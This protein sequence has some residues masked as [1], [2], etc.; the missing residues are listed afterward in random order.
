[1]ANGKHL[2]D[3]WRQFAALL[4]AG[5]VVL[6]FG[7]APLYAQDSPGDTTEEADTSADDPAAAEEETAE[8]GAQTESLDLFELIFQR[9]GVL[10]IP[11]FIMSVIVV[12]FAIERGLALRRAKV[13]PQEMVDELGRLASAP[14]GFDPRKAYRIC[15]RYPSAV[16]NVIRAM[17][18]KV[19]RPHNEIEHAVKEASEREAGRL[20]SNV[21]Y[22]GL[23]AA[24]S[25]LLGLLG[26][27]WGM[28]IAFFQMT[29]LGFSANK[30]LKL[31][32]GIY[33]ALVTTLGGLAVA[34]P[35]AIIAHF[36]EGR[37]QALFHQIDE[38]LFSLLPQIERFE[39]R[40]RVNRQHLAAA[41]ETAVPPSAS[42]SVG[43]EAAS[44]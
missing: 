24:V 3:G 26:T 11:I 38:L 29:Q 43:D 10:M 44:T 27:V 7:S 36:Y 35:A 16:S 22:L 13:I 32:E 20:Y 41:E 2:T 25:P 9:G 39:G 17:L 42:E 6:A 34:I 33:T 14:G 15:Q 4:M 18:L 5:I 12:T 19:G 23:A 21:R 40:L 31:A 8:T 37:I 30:A 1:M 28:I